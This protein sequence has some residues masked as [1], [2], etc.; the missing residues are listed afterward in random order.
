[1]SSSLLPPLPLRRSASLFTMLKS[2]SLLKPSLNPKYLSNFAISHGSLSNN[3]S[4][5]KPGRV[6]KPSFRLVPHAQASGSGRSVWE[7]A[8]EEFFRAKGQ[9]PGSSTIEESSSA[10]TRE[11]GREKLYGRFPANK[12]S[13][14]GDTKSGRRHVDRDVRKNADNRSFDNGPA[15]RSSG[16]QYNKAVS[17]AGR[18]W[19]DMNGEERRGSEGGRT[20]STWSNSAPERRSSKSAWNNNSAAPE[21]RSSKPSWGNN[22]AVR[23]GGSI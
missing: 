7:E 14:Y 22:S 6:L 10:S 19:G 2:I 12:T 23:T 11:K 5:L 15:P 8:A 18:E 3:L 13:D 4:L 20:A 9:K 16:S 21:R 1:M 17:F